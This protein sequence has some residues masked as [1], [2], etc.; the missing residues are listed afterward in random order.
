MQLSAAALGAALLAGLCFGPSA[1]SPLAVSVAHAAEPAAYPLRA[2]LVLPAE[3]PVRIELPPGAVGTEPERL[4][5]TLA[6]F[7]GAGQEVPYAVVPTGAPDPERVTLYSR[8]LGD[9]AWFVAAAERPVDRLSFDWDDI[10]RWGPVSVEVWSQAGD[11]EVKIVEPTLLWSYGVEGE[12]FER[13]SVP[14]PHVAGPFRVQARRLGRRMPDLDWVHGE[15]DPPD[16]VPDVSEVL[17]APAPVLVEGGRARWVLP[18]SGPRVVTGLTIEADGDLYTRQVWVGRPS[19]GTEPAT[20]PA[21]TIRRVLIGE[22]NVDIDAVAVNRVVTDTLVVEVDTDRGRVLPI[23]SFT[24]RS[25]GA[26]LVVRDAGP[27]PHTLYVGGRDRDSAFDLAGGAFELLR[28]DPPRVT[29]GALTGNADYVPLPTRQGV[30]AAGVELN[31]TR[32]AWERPVSGGPGWVVLPL[33]RTVLAHARDDLGDLRVVDTE[34]HQVPYV[35][36]WTGAEVPWSGAETK[37]DGSLPFERTED[38]SASLIRVKLGADLAPVATV[39]LQTDADTFERSVVVLRDRGRVTE[40]LRHVSWSGAVQGGTVSVAVNAV[41]GEELLLRIENGDNPPLPI[42]AVSVTSPGWELRFRAPEGGA[43]LLYGAP[44][45][46]APQYDLAAFDGE[47]THIL[48]A[49]ASLGAESRVG[50]PALGFFDQ[51][52]VYAALGALTLGLLGLTVRV[53]AAVPADPEEPAEPEKP[54]EPAA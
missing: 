13:L 43:R 5:T 24:V 28:M 17:P 44:T 42:R 54:A 34:G 27:G 48:P 39:T 31:L 10:G 14:V 7:N 29:V 41:L 46:G 47:V 33:D 30:D 4:D 9:G 21:G 16:V 19:S 3:G 18:L 49:V 6:L 40:P 50:G 11:R 2:E 22:A 51:A 1:L 26:H 37:P 36:R 15:V 45:Q 38:G 53:I 52:L 35:L 20:E 12:Q 32:F 25:P 8:P 23:R